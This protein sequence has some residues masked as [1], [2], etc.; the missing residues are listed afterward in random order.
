MEGARGR[1]Q[2]GSGIGLALVRELVRLHGG[3]VRVASLLGRGSTFTVTIPLGTS[4]LPEERIGTSESEPSATQSAIPY[5]EEALRWLPESPG[6]SQPHLGTET[7]SGTGGTAR[8]DPPA[9]RPA[10]G[11]RPRILLADDNSDMRSYVQRQLYQTTPQTLLRAAGHGGPPPLSLRPEPR[12]PAFRTR[13]RPRHNRGRLSAHDRTQKPTRTERSTSTSYP[14]PR[15]L[16][17]HSRGSPM[18]KT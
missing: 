8:L 10:S 16:S 3:D 2:E 11:D 7:G 6:S 14:L 9:G 5:V 15:L 18:P 12:R 13:H 4:H 1:T 17:A